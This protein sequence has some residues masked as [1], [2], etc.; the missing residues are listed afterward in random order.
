MSKRRLSIFMFLLTMFA[1]AS[2]V[3]AACARPGAPTASSGTPGSNG[4]SG[5]GGGGSS[6][7]TVHMGPTTFLQSSVT[8]N[9][10]SNLTLVDDAAVVHIIANGTW[11][12][13]TA[14]PKKEAGAPTVNNI[15]FST[16]GQSQSIGPFNTAGTFH[17]Y[18]RVHVNMNLDITVK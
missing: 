9:K 13:G 3:L 7:G 17:L 5:N 6:N 16:A 15:Q 1:L 8:I 18:C 4:G 14:D 2:I 10:G 11:A 12:N